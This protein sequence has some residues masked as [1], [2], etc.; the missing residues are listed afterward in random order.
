MTHTQKPAERKRVRMED[1]RVKVA[2]SKLVKYLQNSLLEAAPPFFRACHALRMNTERQKEGKPHLTKQEFSAA[3]ESP[4][5]KEF[6]RTMV[7]KLEAAASALEYGLCELQPLVINGLPA[8][9]YTPPAVSIAVGLVNEKGKI[10]PVAISHEYVLVQTGTGIFVG[11]YNENTDFES[12]LKGNL[13]LD[14]FI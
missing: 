1:L 4:Q 3:I 6:A 9:H 13:K 8:S 2:G 7:D 12:L 11:K 10:S 5:A 14:S